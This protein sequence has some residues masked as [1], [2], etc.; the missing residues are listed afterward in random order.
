MSQDRGD[1]GNIGDHAIGDRGNLADQL[2]DKGPAEE[3][4]TKAHQINQSYDMFGNPIMPASGDG[5][6]G[7][8]KGNIDKGADRGSLF[9]GA[10]DAGTSLKK[11]QLSKAA[12]VVAGICAISVVGFLVAK[13]AMPSQNKASSDSI[14]RGDGNFL[15]SVTIGGTKSPNEI[16]RQCSPSLVT[17]HIVTKA[18]ALKAGKSKLTTLDDEPILVMPDEDGKLRLFSDGKPSTLAIG[19]V[20]LS[21][22]KLPVAIKLSGGSVILY[23]IGKGGKPVLGKDGEPIRLKLAVDVES[24]TSTAIGSGFFIRPDIVATNWHVVS[25]PSIGTAGFAG[26]LAQITDQPAKYT[27]TDKPIAS[28]KEHDLALLY[29]PGT[30]AKAL[31]M[32]LD[33]GALKV[34]E[35]V[36]ALGSPK[37]LAGSLSEGLISSDKLRGSNPT[38]PD[39]PKLYLQHSAKIDHGNSGGPLVDAR[40]R[41]IGINTAGLG[42]GAINLAVVTRFVDEL[43]K[44]PEVQAK[45]EEFQKKSQS[46]L[47]G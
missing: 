22:G 28:D 30:N 34:G 43:L 27:I 39:S 4:N 45:I 16:F 15:S 17:L 13:F 32:Q 37:G 2:S 11:M 41:V 26:G 24:Y 42:N 19:A 10:K 21:E 9:P 23:P 12:Y 44:K 40:G 6:G 46:D 31:D 29:V 47:H 36:Y 5:S 1:H 25:R 35:P 18:F 33:Y 3:R 7:R 38:D 20:Q 14:G 8:D